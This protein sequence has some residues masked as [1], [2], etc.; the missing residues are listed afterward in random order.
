MNIATGLI[1]LCAGFGVSFVV[2]DLSRTAAGGSW[3]VASGTPAGNFR[4]F[5]IFL[6]LFAG[7]ALFAEVLWR[8][9]RSGRASFA[10][11]IAGVI[12]SAGWAAC[13][14]VVVVECSALAGLRLL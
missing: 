3:P 9:I 5:A 6:A 10:D 13:Y 4:P 12:I 14:G 7:P 2:L 1:L 8:L 11:C